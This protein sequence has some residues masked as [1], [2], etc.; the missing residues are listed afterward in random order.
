MPAK[1]LQKAPWT[2]RTVRSPSA[3]PA[4]GLSNRAMTYK[5]L[6][7]DV[8][9]HYSIGIDVE[10]GT[11]VM[12]VI[13]TQVGWYALYF[14]LQADEVARFNQ[15]PGALTELPQRFAQDKGKWHYRDRLIPSDDRR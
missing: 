9:H 11:H 10:T 12:E 15:D 8:D 7:T 13:I 6:Y 14:R 3:S 4:E 2:G 1:R 5:T